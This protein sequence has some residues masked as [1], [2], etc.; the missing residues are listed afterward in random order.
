MLGL[1]TLCS[2]SVLAGVTACSGTEPCGK[3][4]GRTASGACLPIESG[5]ADGWVAI[6]PEDPTR[7]DRVVAGVHLGGE[8]SSGSALEFGW[9]VDGILV[10]ATGSELA[11]SFFERG[12]R[13]QVQVDLLDGREDL[14]RSNVLVVGNALPPAPEVRVRPRRPMGHVDDLHCEA[15]DVRDPDGDPVEL[16]LSWRVDGERFVPSGD[17]ATVPGEETRGGQTWTCL[18]TPH[19]GVEA[20]PQ[21]RAS[22][23]PESDFVGWDS[24]VNPLVDADYRLI[25]EAP[26]DFGGAGVTNAG[27]VDGDGLG[28]VMVPAYFNDRGAEDAGAVYLYRGQDL[29]AGPGEYAL[30]DA[31]YIFV[32]TDVGEE[33]GHA[34]STA[35]DMDGDGLDDLLICGYRSDEPETD[36]G[37]V[38][39]LYASRLGE[40]RER[41]LDTSD[42]IFIGE[43]VGDRMGHSIS[44]AGDVDGDGSL[45]L[46][47]G[48]YG[49]DA[50]G[51]EAGKTYVVPG[52]TV[53]LGTR[54]LGDQEWMF[55]GE[56]DN[57]SSGHALRT[58]E[59]VDGDGLADFVIGARRV[60]VGAEE[61]GAM[62]LVLGAS[63][64]AVG[65]TISLSDADH[66]FVGEVEM[67]WVGY[68]A[69]GA[70]DVDN[71]GLSDIMAGA[72]MT[73]GETGRVYLM[74]G[75]S[76]AAL[77]KGSHGLNDA[78]MRFDGEHEINH[79]GRSI[80]SAGDVD[81]DG[82]TDLIFGARHHEDGVGRSY[83]NLGGTLTR[84]A[85]DLADSDY[86]FDGEE[87]LDEA[88]YTVS[89]AGDV[90]G[91]GLDDIIIGARQENLTG[92]SGPGMAYLWLSPGADR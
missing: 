87:H 89:G 74:L 40:P 32:G 37:R 23:T 59:D 61:G 33:A 68:Q 77:A 67:G 35:G 8:L 28:D 22:V 45:D 18:A 86:I 70:G 21:G 11:P 55:L 47:M 4:F 53:E 54:E 46:L 63:L 13:I 25:G 2:L 19:D 76:I 12:Q 65:S 69:A 39:L 15:S 58:A 34:T 24:S 50:T 41:R 27:D 90:N 56:G 62:Y 14:L 88:G 26:G 66:R 81:A 9:R 52:H 79:A 30:A 60:S 49:H 29:A 85:H 7:A 48:A 42:V 3:G 92:T 78:D 6:G 43:S 80:A 17:P 36:R 38:Y 84:G 31:P 82:H 75:S 44:N 83:L 10:E 73:H 91:D 51:N 64:G 20:G 57:H 5:L 71:D 16:R 1:R 72:H